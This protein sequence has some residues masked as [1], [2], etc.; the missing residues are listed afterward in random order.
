MSSAEQISRT[1]EEWREHQADE[2]RRALRELLTLC[3]QARE[4]GAHWYRWIVEGRPELTP[5]EYERERVA[6]RRRR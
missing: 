6:R 3:R 2:R 1:P 5:E 4:S